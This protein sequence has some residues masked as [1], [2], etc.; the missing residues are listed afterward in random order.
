MSDINVC[1]FSGNIGKDC[2]IRPFNNGKGAVSFSLAVTNSWTDANKVRQETTN[3]LE[4]ERI[5]SEDFMAYAKQYYVKGQTAV[6][7]A[8]A[9]NK[10]WVSDGVTHRKIVFSVVD[11]TLKGDI[12]GRVQGRAQQPQSQSQPQSHAPQQQ[13]QPAAQR[14]YGAAAPGVPSFSYAD[15]EDIGY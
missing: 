11:M 1:T 13:P 14:P 10:E 5:G 15:E 2:V 3:W 8:K 6:V 12:K 9:I 4:F 7:H